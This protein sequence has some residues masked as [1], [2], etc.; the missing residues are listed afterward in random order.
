LAT[1]RRDTGTCN[2]ARLVAGGM[3]RRTPAPAAPSALRTARRPRPWPERDEAAKEQEEGGGGSAAGDREPPLS[4]RWGGR[5]RAGRGRTAK[6]GTFPQQR[7]QSTEVELLYLLQVLGQQ[8]FPQ[9]KD[10]VFETAVHLQAPA[11]RGGGGGGGEGGG[12]GVG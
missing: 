5:E 1:T 2:G 12:G 8:L 9:R 10:A 6:G 4:G 11:G 3:A 7:Q